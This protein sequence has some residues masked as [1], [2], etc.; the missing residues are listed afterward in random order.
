MNANDMHNFANA[1]LAKFICQVMTVMIIFIV[2][3]FAL[4]TNPRNYKR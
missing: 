3:I 4:C 1:M 2:Y